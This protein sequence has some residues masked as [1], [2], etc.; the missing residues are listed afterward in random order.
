MLRSIGSARSTAAWMKRPHCWLYE[1]R[2]NAHRPP[3]P[4]PRYHKH[5]GFHLPH[6]T[7]LRE[8]HTNTILT[9]TLLYW[10]HCTSTFQEQHKWR[11]EEWVGSYMEGRAAETHI[12]PA[13]ETLSL[14]GSPTAQHPYLRYKTHKK[15]REHPFSYMKP[16]L[17]SP[18]ACPYS[19]YKGKRL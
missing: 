15:E 9:V 1:E 5:S 16:N 8:Y 12:D 17:I 6:H 18:P 4:Y 14:V 19:L 10:A 7:F 3:R 13:R 2:L 11:P